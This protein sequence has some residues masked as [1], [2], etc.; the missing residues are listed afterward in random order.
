MT[1]EEYIE[2]EIEDVNKIAGDMIC[3]DA[4]IL[5]DAASIE[6]PE[7]AKEDGRFLVYDNNRVDVLR[8][9]CGKRT[10]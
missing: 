2:A 10:S 1:I 9:F 7:L 5:V 3:N 8:T 6:N 4:V